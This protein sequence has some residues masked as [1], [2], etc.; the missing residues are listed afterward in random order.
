MKKELEIVRENYSKSMAEQ[1]KG[2]EKEIFDALKSMAINESQLHSAQ[3]MSTVKQNDWVL[4]TTTVTDE[5]KVKEKKTECDR[6][7]KAIDKAENDKDAAKK[8]KLELKR[9]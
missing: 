6:L 8:R 1:L 9:N 4:F 2:E 7:R 5:S 3:N